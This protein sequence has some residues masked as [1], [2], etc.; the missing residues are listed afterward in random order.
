MLAG[1][2]GGHVTMAVTEPATAKG[3]TTVVARCFD[4]VSGS[5]SPGPVVEWTFDG[6]TAEV[7]CVEDVL[8]QRSGLVLPSILVQCTKQGG[9]GGRGGGRT[10]GTLVCIGVDPATASAGALCISNISVDI[11][12]VVTPFLGPGPHILWEEK[13]KRHSGG[14]GGGGG[15]DAVLMVS[16]LVGGGSSD[17]RTLYCRKGECISA[18]AEVAGS[19][20]NNSC[21]SS[22]L[23]VGSTPELGATAI[24]ATGLTDNNKGRRPGTGNAAHAG[25]YVQ[26]C[27]IALSSK[28][29]SRPDTVLLLGKEDKADIKADVGAGTHLPPQKRI[30]LQTEQTT[31]YVGDG[32][33]KSPPR[34]AG[35]GEGAGGGEKTGTTAVQNSF[36]EQRQ[37]IEKERVISRVLSL[38]QIPPVYS[39]TA[40]C[41]TVLQDPT[42]THPATTLSPPSQLY[43]GHKDSLQAP[44]IFVRLHP[45]FFAAAIMCMRAQKIGLHMCGWVGGRVCVCVCVRV[46][47]SLSLSLYV[48]KG[49]MNC[50][51]PELFKP[52]PL[53]TLCLC[54][55]LV[56]SQELPA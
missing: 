12:V 27:A 9:G 4:V 36:Q 47:L 17:P 43:M 33:A 13:A 50:C 45:F 40:I 16:P 39:A 2:N 21:S 19:S 18:M 29:K 15:G 26:W 6:C 32:P 25:G 46:S 24:V 49:F 1:G 22:V 14:G 37:A 11:G 30:K 28:S 34:E 44:S 31:E 38:Y 54:L 53:P 48:C 42:P 7:L 10:D 55:K 23:W 5:M 3:G 51:K 56:L 20:S 52:I 41:I 35:G 8:D